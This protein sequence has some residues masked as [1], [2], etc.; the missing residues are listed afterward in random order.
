[1]VQA[2]I[3]KEELE[4]LREKY[5]VGCTVELIK[6]DDVQAPPLHTKGVVR[7]IDD[8]GTI[9]VNWS[10]GSGLGVVYGEDYVKKI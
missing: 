2:M 10:T 7:H 6:M 8:M 5:P 4:N 3:K 9:F 1:M